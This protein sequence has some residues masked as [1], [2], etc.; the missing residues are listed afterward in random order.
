VSLADDVRAGLTRDGLKEISP[1]YL[2]DARGSELFDLITEQPEYYPTRCERAILERYAAECVDGHRELVELGSGVASKTRVLLAAGALE[3]YVPFDVDRSVVEMCEREL[4]ADFP[5]LVV[6]GIHGDF[7][8][9]L[10]VIPAGGPRVIALLGGTIGNLKPPERA[11]FLRSLRARLGATDR[12]LL[13]VD[14][15]KDVEVLEAAYNDAAGVSAEFALNLLRV[16]NRELGA[17]FDVDAFDY[18]AFFDPHESWIDMRLRARHA[19]R[20]NTPG[21]GLE[22]EL[23]PGE[24]IRTETSA[25]FTRDRLSR[26]LGDAGL[27]IERF[28]TDPHALFGLSLCAPL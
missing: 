28:F 26:E 15:V 4:S 5:D 20:V 12:F 22:I 17:D 24:D 19:Q 6:E 14:L 7:N 27:E 16:L 8:A 2:Y 3:R 11:T 10:D 13:G 18:V 25:K 21:A 9:N 1:K 23:A